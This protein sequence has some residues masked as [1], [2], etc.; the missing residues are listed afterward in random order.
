MENNRI[1]ISDSEST[2]KEGCHLNH[3]PVAIKGDLC[4]HTH[5]INQKFNSVSVFVNE[6]IE[7]LV[8]SSDKRI[9]RI[10]HHTLS[11]SNLVH[12]FLISILSEI[13]FWISELEFIYKEKNKSKTDTLYI[14]SHTPTDDTSV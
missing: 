12:L 13:C 5:W 10:S 11:G 3:F 6:V 8:V 1:I 9:V 7:L 14:A 2:V 4:E